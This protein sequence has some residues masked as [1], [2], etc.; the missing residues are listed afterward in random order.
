M[1]LQLRLVTDSVVECQVQLNLQSLSGQWASIS[2]CPNMNFSSLGCLS[3]SKFCMNLGNVNFNL[4]SNFCETDPN[5]WGAICH[6][7]P[8][9]MSP[10]MKDSFLSTQNLDWFFIYLFSCLI[11]IEI[12]D[13]GSTRG[14]RSWGTSWQTSA[15]TINVAMIIYDIYI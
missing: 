4:L 6:Q 10:F 5:S 12:R 3:A 8:K 1:S 15:S 2:Q 11:T 7:C 13:A 9:I 14:A